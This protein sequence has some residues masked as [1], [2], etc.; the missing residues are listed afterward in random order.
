MQEGGLCLPC[1]QDNWHTRQ[2]AHIHADRHCRGQ[3]N[4][5]QGKRACLLCARSVKNYTTSP[6]TSHS[7]RRQPSADRNHARGLFRM[8]SR[9][10]R[11]RGLQPYNAAWPIMAQRNHAATDPCIPAP[12]TATPN[13]MQPSTRRARRAMQIRPESRCKGFAG[14]PYIHHARHIARAASGHFKRFSGFS[15][16]ARQ[17]SATQSRPVAR[18]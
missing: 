6:C 7:A 10:R 1:N 2:P 3:R 12:T 13:D 15:V 8:Q 16:N 5:C 17:F 11:W 14:T 18:D 9:R 4:R